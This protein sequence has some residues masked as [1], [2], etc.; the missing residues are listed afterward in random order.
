MICKTAVIIT[1]L[2][3]SM[4]GAKASFMMSI[5]PVSLI[6]GFDIGIKTNGFVPLFGID[7]GSLSTRSENTYVT[8]DTTYTSEYKMSGSIFVPHLGFKVLF[9]SGD[10]RP[11][12]GLQ[13]LYTLGTANFEVD[14]VR[15][16]PMTEQVKNALNGNWGFDFDFGGEY[17]FGDQFSL[18]GAIGFSYFF[19]SMEFEDEWMPGYIDQYKDTMGLGFFG[20]T[21]GFNFY[22]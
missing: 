14:G 20:T 16:A 5:K 1:M 3:V 10:L 18:G 21:W 7:F 11:Y 2:F 15:D 22:F 17:F 6:E 4:A 13:G 9:G 19:G 8:P 12:L